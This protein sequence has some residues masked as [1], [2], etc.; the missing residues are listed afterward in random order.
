MPLLEDL[1][2]D[3]KDRID[4]VDN[5]QDMLT[6]FNR[7]SAPLDSEVLEPYFIWYRLKLPEE[8]PDYVTNAEKYLNYA[9]DTYVRYATEVENVRLI[10]LGDT[11]INKA[12]NLTVLPEM[13][14]LI[15]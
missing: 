4:R 5:A 12:L 9:T 6:L 1:Q 2:Q 14:E 3:L 8:I 7:I 13:V 11:L 10:D 15:T